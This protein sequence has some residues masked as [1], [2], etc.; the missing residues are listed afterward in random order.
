MILSPQNPDASSYTY[1]MA[2]FFPRTRHILSVL[3]LLPTLRVSGVELDDVPML[4]EEKSKDATRNAVLNPR[5]D[6]A[7]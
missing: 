6:H 5:F 3:S 4:R 1:S 7:E 2:S